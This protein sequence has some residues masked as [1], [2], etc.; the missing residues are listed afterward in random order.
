M[1][2]WCT[3]IHTAV[4]IT[5]LVPINSHQTLTPTQQHR[6]SFCQL[7]SCCIDKIPS[8]FYYFLFLDTRSNPQFAD[9]AVSRKGTGLVQ[10]VLW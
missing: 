8:S 5:T 3:Y 7:W 10:N 2:Q 9:A 6:F 4:L 1:V